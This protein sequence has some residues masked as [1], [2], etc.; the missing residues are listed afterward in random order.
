MYCKRQRKD[1]PFKPSR[2]TLLRI[3]RGGG[4]G[5]R[6]ALHQIGG[7]GSEAKNKFVYLQLASD[8]G[9]LQ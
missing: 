7:G 4:G 2:S 5:G 1:T 6:W 9:P 8:Y 3:A